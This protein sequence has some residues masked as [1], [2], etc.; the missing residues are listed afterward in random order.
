MITSRA[1]R[2]VAELWT[3]RTV[4]E[5]WDIAQKFLDEEADEMAGTWQKGGDYDRPES[6]S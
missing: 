6:C 1:K 5:A 2:L 4:E 3:V